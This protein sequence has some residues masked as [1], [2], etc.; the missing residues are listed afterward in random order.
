MNICLVVTGTWLMF[1]HMLGIMWNNHPNWL[2]YFSEGLNHQP[3]TVYSSLS[4]ISSGYIIYIWFRPARSNS[5]LIKLATF[6][7]TPFT[8][9]PIYYKKGPQFQV[10]SEYRWTVDVSTIYPTF[11]QIGNWLLIINHKSPIIGGSVAIFKAKILHFLPIC[12]P[13]QLSPWGNALRIS[14]ITRIS[15]REG[16]RLRSSKWP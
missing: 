1:F 10:S 14:L 16:R 9:T 13:P 5:I 2:S 4:L 6:G 15:L 8:V 11:I 3:D 12:C 7:Y